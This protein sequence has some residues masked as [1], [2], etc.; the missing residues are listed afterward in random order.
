ME[1]K[2][3]STKASK[4]ATSGA[5]SESAGA[6]QAADRTILQTSP[7]IIGGGSVGIGFNDTHY[8]GGEGRYVHPNDEIST[9]F[10]NN[11]FGGCEH[12]FHDYVHGRECK[13]TVHT[14]IN[15]ARE[16]LITVTSRPNG[17]LQ[18]S[19]DETEFRFDAIKKV[20]Y[21]P[22]RKVTDSI[23]VENS[24]GKSTFYVPNDGACSIQIVNKL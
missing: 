23:E 12:N 17:P 13:I 18:I 11:L 10:V 2:R 5:R 7:I 1:K 8:T 21:H 16:K 24:S 19:F 9:A 14:R 15:G 3:A 22:D 20:R 4:A 6:D